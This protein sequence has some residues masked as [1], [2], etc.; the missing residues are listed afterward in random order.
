MYSDVRL[1]A[2]HPTV[3]ERV[4]DVC[5]P[6]ATTAPVAALVRGLVETAARAWAER[7]PPTRIPVALLRLASRRAGQT[8]PA[9][10][11][12]HPVPTRA[13][14][15]RTVVGALYEH[16]RDAWRR[17]VTRRPS[18]PL[19]RKRSLRAGDGRGDT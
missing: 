15:A 19:R 6:A 16:V 2:T 18:V 8:G 12:L 17:A 9:G 7:E 3:E 5:L 11:L 1:S 13:A 10:S 4:A 14:T